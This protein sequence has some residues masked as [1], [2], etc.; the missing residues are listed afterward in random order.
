[1]RRT[2]G[3]TLVELGLA[4]LV[5]SIV[6]GALIQ[7]LMTGAQSASRAGES[8][9]VAVAG[10]RAIDRMVAAGYAALQANAG[11]AGEMALA[12]GI[13]PDSGAA[14]PVKVR[15]KI[16][17]VDPQLVRVGVTLTWKPAGSAASASELAMHLF[18]YVGDS[19]CSQ[20]RARGVGGV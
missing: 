13:D 16:E 14:L 17:Q 3:M 8:Q 19:S 2:R 15:F 1:M 11:T 6:G 7:A 9:L 10:A 20:G 18:R 4:L 12:P 5:L